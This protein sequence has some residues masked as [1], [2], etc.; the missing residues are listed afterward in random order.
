MTSLNDLNTYEKTSN[1]GQQGFVES[2]SNKQQGFVES[3]YGN[4]KEYENILSYPKQARAIQSQLQQEETYPKE[5]FHMAPQEIM[6]N[7]RNLQKDNT[8]ML[9]STIVLLEAL[10]ILLLLRKI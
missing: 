5:Y 2:Y 4:P 7:I 9:L 10:I 6:F 3:Y 8:I 1:D